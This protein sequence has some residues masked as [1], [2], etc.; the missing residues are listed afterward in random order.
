M[1]AVIMGATGLGLSSR[2]MVALAGGDGSK[3]CSQCGTPKIVDDMLTAQGLPVVCMGCASTAPAI[4]RAEQ[5]VRAG[6]ERKATAYDR[7][8]EQAGSDVQLQATM[9]TAEDG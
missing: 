8:S 2:R 9:R 6:L 4:T 5:D 3:V 7:L 1:T